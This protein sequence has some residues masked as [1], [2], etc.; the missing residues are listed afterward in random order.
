MRPVR[1]LG[2]IAVSALLLACS[3]QGTRAPG[4]PPPKSEP[5]P[6]APAPPAQEPELPLTAERDADGNRV[7]DV[8]DQQLARAQGNPQDMARQAPLQVVLKQAVQQGD[9]DDFVAEGG[10]LR[11][12][13]RELS[14]GW[15]G[16]LPL[17]KLPRLTARL[18]GKLHLLAAPRSVVPFMDE[19]TR[20]GRIRGIWASGFAGNVSGYSGNP[21]ITVAVLDTGVDS[22]HTDLSGR[23]Q[24]FKDYTTDAAVS[25]RDVE[26]HGTHVTSIAVG[27]GAAF[28]AASGTL[29]FTQSGS[30]TGIPSGS[31][32]SGTIHTPT[33][34]GSGAS[35]N[36]SVG[37]TFLG[38]A[39]TTLHALYAPDASQAYTSFGNVSGTSPLS[40]SN[41]NGGVAGMIFQGGLIQS[42]PA[43][44]TSFA[45]T[46]SV[47]N[48]PG[49][50][51]GFNSL[52]GVAPT[53][54]YFGAKVF[55]DDATGTS[56]DI[57][58]ALDD[59]VSRKV[60]DN[61][62]VAN[63]SLGVSGSGTDTVVRAAVNTAVD[64]GVVV[65][66]AA[67]NDG[68][69]TTMGDPGRA[70][71]VITVGASNDV[72]ELTTYT[73]LG[74][75]APGADEDTKP[76]VLAPGGSFYRSGILAADSNTNDGNS[77]G[78]G[79]L[80]AN[81]YSSL[82]GTSM[83]TPFVSGSIA[84]MIDALQQSGTTWNFGSST[85]PLFVKMLLGASA[86]EIN[87]S[88][89]QASAN[90]PTLGRATT[91]KDRFEGYGIINPDAA[92]EALVQNFSSPVS[93]S[94]SN[95][96]PARLEWERR[97]W[98]RKLG[99]VNGSVV[100]FNLT[101]PATADYDLYLY[102][103]SPDA[104][105][106]PVLRA[107]SVKAGNDSDESISFTSS[108]TETAYVFVKRVSG[109]GSFTLTGSNTNHCGDGDL[110]AGEVCDPAM[111][112]S[113]TCCTSTCSAVANNTS[114]SDGDKCT[115]TDKCQAGVCVGSNPVS[116]KALD[117]CHD[118]GV[119]DSATG[120][121]STPKKAENTS[122]DDNDK[123]TQTD[124]CVSGVCTG[125]N[126][127]SC[128]A[129]D[130]C[131]DVGTCDAATGKCSDPKKAEN[132][133]CNDNDKCTQ[134]DKCVSGVCTGTNP[135]SC[136]ASDQCH[137]VGTCDSATGTC[138]N[139]K[140]AD[141]TSC[142]DGDKCTSSDTCQAGVCTGGT[143]TACTASDQ[144]HDA[145]TCDAATGTCSNPAKPDDTACNDGSKCTQSDTCQAG[146]CTGASAITCTASDQCHSAGTCDAATGVCSNPKKAD[147]TAC[148]DGNACTQTDTCQ[149]G[150]CTGASPI[151]C[152]A[153]DQCHSAGT[154][155]AATGLCSN[156]A[157]TNGSACNDGSKCTRTDTCQAGVCS[158]ANPVTCAALDQCHDAG[159]CDGATGACS[160][161]AKSNG[162]TCDD[163]NACTRTDTCQA[164]ACQGA[165]PVVCA[166]V[167]ECHQAGVCDT[168]T[169]ACSNPAKVNGSPCD[170]GDA[171]SQTDTCQG[172]TCTGKNPVIC[173]APDQCHDAGSCD[174]ASGVCSN[175]AKP[176]GSACNDGN[177]CTRS[178]SCQ[179]G[180][181][182]GSSPVVCVASDQCHDAGVC[183]TLTGACSNPQKADGAACDDGDGCTQTDSCTAGACSGTNPVVCTALDQCHVAGSCDQ[184]SGVCS[185]PSVGDGTA[186][187]DGDD[188]TAGDACENGV[189]VAGK[190]LGCAGGAG[191]SVG[192]GGTANGGAA[193]GGN[194]GAASG[195]NAGTAPGGTASG[196]GASS[197]SAAAG[198]SGSES[199]AAG[200]PSEPSS[201]G[202]A[203][204]D[205]EPSQAG[206]AA[207]PDAAAARQSSGCGCQVPGTPTPSGAAWL[208]AGALVVALRRRRAA[209]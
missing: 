168:A 180:V 44:V 209:A 57:Q 147:K 28:G 133:G 56:L 18:G 20:T 141:N 80:V 197:G 68:P 30:L 152:T 36:V 60:A 98:G 55:L 172:G 73:S 104:K 69:S 112:A 201:S 154:C 46:N 110:D 189:C 8:L 12:V 78:F 139:P 51:D 208:A 83:A 10:K 27:T 106:N 145:G 127:V 131:H 121:C 13:F 179:A 5:Q 143:A 14:Y 177:T 137:G 130:Q 39:S 111:V 138:S 148:D 32:L 53:C 54:K 122:C 21:N 16:S 116:C 84:L 82:Q 207:L 163:G 45:V 33:Y 173:P 100:T 204:A 42:T 191:G 188:C 9:L 3:D 88:R 76:D 15:T 105:G 149:A 165:S 136:A 35:L 89:E 203:P 74:P 97:A 29:K 71:K 17:E 129:S 205:P 114:C 195:G 181:C 47:S 161:P 86:T 65:V 95:V 144:C 40:L 124:K 99:L 155:D 102:A 66:V 70:S 90:S 198:S 43:N 11:Y 75:S 170:D 158:G 61:I 184:T 1:V 146:V 59:V 81:D 109:Y 50:G 108:A 25:A 125:S 160:N 4:A 24:G 196:G 6:V 92:I 22:S 176:N 157:K 101:V 135:V 113:T 87:A 7:D 48:Y 167:D 119:C 38:G 183:D 37:A 126:P 72:N 142:N 190:E 96:A 193:P 169:G 178:D 186:C 94:V 164:G 162:A 194:G 156:P 117:Q 200:A 120:S 41:Q 26:G 171:C 199:S 31:F 166:A 93:G 52:R 132:T 192:S 187:S 140:K 153:S 175:P 91:P 185:N 67:G 115:Q 63:L 34:L 58:E 202:G 206:T 79:D 62:K 128:S 85:Q 182:V 64:A 123:C 107:S 118:V 103:G 134:T 174:G 151:T 23:L 150:V 77:K 19:A 159:T 49:V 2:A